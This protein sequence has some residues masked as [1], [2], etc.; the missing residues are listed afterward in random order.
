MKKSLRQQLK[1]LRENIHY[2]QMRGRMERS[3]ILSINR[4][5]K[6]IGEKMRL[7]QSQMKK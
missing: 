2:F 4:K 7:I 1:E 5:C 6:E 3:S